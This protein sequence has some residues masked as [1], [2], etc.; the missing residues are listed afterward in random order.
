VVLRVRFG[1]FF[2]L[3]T[4]DVIEEAESILLA[5]GQSLD[6]LVPKV[7]HHRGGT[8]LTTPFLEAVIPKPA[9]ISAGADNRF[10]HPHDVTLEKLGDIPSYRTE[11]D[12]SI[13]VA[14]DGEMYWIRTDR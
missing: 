11:M 3:L 5:P 9:I 12:G 6:S 4:G 1:Q 10:G 8:S 7:P 13:E 14:T 2:V